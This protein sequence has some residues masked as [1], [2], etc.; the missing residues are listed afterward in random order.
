MLIHHLFSVIESKIL[1]NY[2]LHFAGGK[3][4]RSSCRMHQLCSLYK[5]KLIFVDQKVFLYKVY[6]L[7]P[8][9]GM[10]LGTILASLGWW[11][12]SDSSICFMCSSSNFWAVVIWKEKSILHCTVKKQCRMYFSSFRE[13]HCQQ[14]MCLIPSEEEQSPRRSF[15]TQKKAL[16]LYW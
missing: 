11:P 4:K 1:Q 14:S 5:F 12:L 3:L 15:V 6:M 13:T 2:N 8:E 10:L 7:E 9:S 16:L